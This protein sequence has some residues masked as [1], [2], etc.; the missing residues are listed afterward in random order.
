[1]VYD[2][3]RSQFWNRYKIYQKFLGLFEVMLDGFLNLLIYIFMRIMIFSFL[4]DDWVN[5]KQEVLEF[6][7]NLLGF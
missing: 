3:Y 5:F 6:F 7:N 4:E 1:M 2:I